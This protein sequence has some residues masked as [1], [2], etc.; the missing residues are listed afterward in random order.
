M[1]AL[2]KQSWKLKLFLWC[3]VEVFA[4]FVSATGEF[5]LFWIS[6]SLL[7]CQFLKWAIDWLLRFCMFLPSMPAKAFL[8]IPNC[9]S[10]FGMHFVVAL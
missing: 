5:L 3:F 4:V 1:M 6:F 8:S 10:L 9:L 7:C 2:E